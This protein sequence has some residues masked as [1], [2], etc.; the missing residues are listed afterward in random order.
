[1]PSIMNILSPISNLFGDSASAGQK[2]AAAQSQDLANSFQDSFTKRFG[3]Q[4]DTLG[5]INT[6]MGQLATGNTGFG[7]GAAEQADLSSTIMNTYAAQ[8]QNEL[9][10]VMDKSA[11]QTFGNTGNGIKSGV[12]KQLTQEAASDAAKNQANALLSEKAAGWQQGR[13]NVKE[14]ATGHLQE[15]QIENPEKYGEMATTANK[16]SWDDQTALFQQ[17]QQQDHAIMGLVA[18]AATTAL[19]GGIGGFAGLAGSAAGASQPL[20]FLQGAGNALRGG[21]FGSGG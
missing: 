16:Q 8:G 14:A 12:T 5:Q 21:S 17:Q 1:M 2:R 4:S 7:F 13:T 15:A 9:Q 11:G 3:E 18:G 20:A 19:T 6:E 10:A